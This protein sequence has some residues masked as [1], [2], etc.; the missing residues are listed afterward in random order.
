MAI[1]KPSS[2]TDSPIGAKPVDNFGQSAQ[3]PTTTFVESIWSVEY[4]RQ[5]PQNAAEAIKTLQD[6]LNDRDWQIT[7]LKVGIKNIR[8]ALDERL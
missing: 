2:T 5:H 8:E 1:G 7:A 6:T 4:C 3:K